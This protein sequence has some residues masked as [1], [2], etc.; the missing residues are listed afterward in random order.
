MP[1]GIEGEVLLGSVLLTV[2][3]WEDPQCPQQRAL[4]WDWPN[5]AHRP[6]IRQSE[7]REITGCP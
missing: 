1:G 4:G 6:A 3:S 7:E 5:E 2:D